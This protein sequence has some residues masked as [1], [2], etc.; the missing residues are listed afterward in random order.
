MYSTPV[1]SKLVMFGMGGFLGSKL[2]SPPRIN[3]NRHPAL[4]QLR[5]ARKTLGSG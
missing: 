2:P 3:N 1:S 4:L 5:S